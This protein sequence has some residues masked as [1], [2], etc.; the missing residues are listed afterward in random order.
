MNKVDLSV[1]ET[2]KEACASLRHYSQAALHIR[3]SAIAHCVVLVTAIGY[4]LKE[5][6]VIFASYAS[7]FG[8]VFTYTL[9]A[10]HD[11]YQRKVTIFIKASSE[12]EKQFELSVFPVADLMNEHE[13]HVHNLTGELLITKGLFILMIAAFSFLLIQAFI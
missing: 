7:G 4:L 5:N 3:I 10:L 8:L 1:I 12:L 2:Y 13:N 9:M 6:S 11:S